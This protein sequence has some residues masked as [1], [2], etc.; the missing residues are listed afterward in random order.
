MPAFTIQHTSLQATD[1]DAQRRQ[2]AERVFAY[3][4]RHDNEVLTGT[5]AGTSP[6]REAIPAAAKAHGYACYVASPGD[7]WIAVD[8][9]WA[10]MRVVDRDFEKVVDAGHGHG[11]RGVGFLVVQTRFG[12][13]AFASLHLLAPHSVD[14]E[15]HANDRLRDRAV[16]WAKDHGPLSFVDAD[17]NTND[18]K[19][20]VWHSPSLV[21]CWDE[22]GKYPG[23]IEGGAKFT[24]DVISRLKASRAE[25]TGAQRVGDAVF[26]LNADHQLIQ[27]KVQIP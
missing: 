7:S 24:I 10:D 9:R 19:R 5:E 21:T 6:T 17:T 27:A 22:V 15:P 4:R 14:D 16:E 13:L 25:F 11:P 20:N 1:P 8:Q 18:E 23:T 26:R 2:D 12:R 3:A